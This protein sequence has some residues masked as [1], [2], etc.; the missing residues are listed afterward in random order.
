MNLHKRSWFIT[1]VTT[2]CGNLR[3][4]HSSI[5]CLQY[6]VGTSESSS[7]FL[8]SDRERTEASHTRFS[9]QTCKWCASPFTFYHLELSHVVILYYKGV[10]VMSSSCVPCEKRTP[11]RW[12]F[13]ATDGIRIGIEVIEKN[14]EKT[15]VPE[16]RLGLSKQIPLE[17]RVYIFTLGMET[18][19]LM[20]INLSLCLLQNEMDC[21]S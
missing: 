7:R 12:L 13:S 6:R 21:A 16:P 1:H 5:L 15:L 3:T 11:C 9:V 10:W 2:Q 8:A 17:M 14:V 19:G 18:L 4:Q 20:S